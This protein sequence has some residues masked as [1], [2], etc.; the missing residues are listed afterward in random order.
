MPKV[1]RKRG[2]VA[3]VA[4]PLFIVAALMMDVASNSAAARAI[5][6]AGLRPAIERRARLVRTFEEEPAHQTAEA[7]SRAFRAEAA[8]HRPAPLLAALLALALTA[9]ALAHS[10]GLRLGRIA[11]RIR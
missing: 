8:L 6:P 1:E 3:Y 5:D 9:A 2:P 4:G 10:A 11:T 7:S